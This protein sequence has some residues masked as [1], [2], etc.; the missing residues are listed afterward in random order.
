MNN[1]IY[2][3]GPISNYPTKKKK[4]KIGKKQIGENS[5]HSLILSRYT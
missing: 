2:Q 5:Q 4:A 3:S 1:H